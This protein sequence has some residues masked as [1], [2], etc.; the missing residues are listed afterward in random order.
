MLELC[1]LCGTFASLQETLLSI[2]TNIEDG[3]LAKTQ[4]TAK[5]AKPI[6]YVEARSNLAQFENP[7]FVMLKV[8]I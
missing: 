4:S 2:V 1:E 7:T 8:M 6:E 3:V 5:L